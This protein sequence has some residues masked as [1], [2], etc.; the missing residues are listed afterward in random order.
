[1]E[2]IARNLERGIATH[3]AILEPEKKAPEFIKP[4]WWDMPQEESYTGRCRSVIKNFL[5]GNLHGKITTLVSNGQHI[6]STRNNGKEL[7][8]YKNNPSVKVNICVARKVDGGYIGNSSGMMAMRNALSKKIGW[9]GTQQKIQE[10]MAECIP[11]VPFLIFKEARLDINS[12]EIVEKGQQERLEVFRLWSKVIEGRHYTGAMVFKM[13]IV[14]RS[15]GVMGKTEDYYLFDIDRN[16]LKLKVFNPFLSKLP[17]PAK[18]IAEAYALLKPK[19]IS[20]AERFLG[21]ECERQGEWFFIPV[22]GRFKRQRDESARLGRK[23]FLQARLSSKG[24]RPHTVQFLSEEGY[25]TGR[26]NHTGGEHPEMYLK[27][28]HKPV[29]NGAVESFKISGAVD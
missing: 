22:Q 6:Y 9:T 3:R 10:V 25:V 29:G 28:W 18:T 13:N 8:L 26:V 12:F 7:W 5:N 21:R 19:E 27:G 23:P 2:S 14:S 20:D 11:M 4:T 17:G 15:R 1:M 16:D 24:Q